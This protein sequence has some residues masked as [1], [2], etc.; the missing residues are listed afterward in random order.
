MADSGL[1]F[2][3]VFKVANEIDSCSE[4]ERAVSFVVFCA[5][6]SNKTVNG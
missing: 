2:G 1:A 4:A 6:G 5:A 3:T